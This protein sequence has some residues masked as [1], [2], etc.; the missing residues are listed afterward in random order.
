M[1]LD[2]LHGILM[3][4]KDSEDS[5]YEYQVWF[6]YTK[7]SINTIREG[8]LIAVKN[9]ASNDA[10]SYNSVLQITSVLPMHYALGKDRSGYPAFVEEAAISVSQDWLQETP[11][12]ETTKIIC[13]AIPTN[14]EIAI[15]S[16]LTSQNQQE[17]EIQ[18]E[19]NIPMIGEKARMLNAEWTGKLVNRDIEKR[20]SE[21]IEIG[22]LIKSPE[23][24]VL[25]LWEEIVRIHFG[26]FAFTGAGKSNLASTCAAKMLEKST[27]LKMVF[28]DLLGEYI[29]LLIDVLVNVKDAAI[30][31][32]TAE[33]VPNSVYD[34]W[35]NPS[36]TNLDKAASDIVTTSLLPKT[37]QPY[38]HKFIEPIKKMLSDRKIRLLRETRSLGDII[39][40]LAGG[41]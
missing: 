23:I 12:E 13:R 5:Q 8:S 2:N 26:I 11:T 10:E 38:K 29:T 35:V 4:I 33:A 32:L 17:P 20:K 27:N 25:A 6:P 18:G 3:D 37:L 31:A 24:G 22:S 39:E 16:S 1:F 15:Q 21:T 41:N 14:Y 36:D 30:V 28:Y 9:F 19:S 7:K 34:Y 40:A